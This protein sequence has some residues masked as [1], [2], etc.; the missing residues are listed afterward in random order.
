MRTIAALAMIVAALPAQQKKG[1]EAKKQAAQK[2]AVE[3]LPKLAGAI[4]GV[5]VSDPA[6]QSDWPAAAYARDGS[7]YVVYIEW[8]DKDADRVLARRR[9]AG[10]QWSAPIPIDDGAWDHYSPAVAGL[11]NGAL[12]IWSAQRDG[13]F[14][15]FAAEIAGVTPGRVERLTRAPHGDFN[16]R[17]VADAKGNV[18]LVWQSF[19]NGASDVYARRR[20]AGRWGPEVRV[21][22]SD[23]GDWEPSIALSAEGMAWISWDSYQHGNYDVFLR[24]FDG[25]RLGDIVTM[26]TEPAAQFHSSVAVDARG[27]VWVAWDQGGPHWGKDLSASSGMPGYSGLHSV[28][29]LRLR[30]WAN[31]R[32][33]DPPA[34]LN[35][36]LTAGMQQFAELPHLGFDDSGALWMVFRH[37]THRQPHEIYHF[38]ATRL[39][40]DRWTLP[41][42]LTASPGQNTQHASLTRA[43]HGGLSAVYS[44]DGRSPANLPKDQMHA[45]HY[46]VH[47]SELAKGAA[48]VKVAMKPAA[49]PP[50]GAPSPRR[51]RHTMRAGSR[52]YTLMMGDCHRHTDIRGHSGVDASVLDTY[53]Y[54]IDAGQ[55][56]FLGVTDHNEVLGGDW[57]DGLRDYHW[58]WTQKA[59]D[60]F[61]HAPAFVGV[62]SYEHSMARPGGH[63]NVLFLKRGA[64]LRP[65]D[66]RRQAPEP[67]NLPPAM[68]KFWE[69]RV[70]ADRG[71]MSVIVPHTFAA[72][73]LADWNWPNAR[74]DC[75]LEIYQGCRGSYEAWRMPDGEKRGGTQV[76]E[77]GHFAQDALAKG[78]VYG[79]VSFSDHGSTHNSWAAVWVEREDRRGILE[80]M[81]ARRTYAASDEI[82]LRATADGRMVGEEFAARADR[83]PR[84][85]AAVEAPDAILRIDIVKDGKYVYTTRPNSTRARISWRDTEARPGRS[86]YYLRV[87][88]RDP[89]APSGD[90]EI[91]WA[92]PFYVTYR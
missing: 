64:P 28:R 19:R 75:L 59:V 8:N 68:W 29:R 67:D 74:F 15:L 32:V 16:A 42:Q 35:E 13:N 26:T 38:Y 48:P 61:T 79:F 80:G 50:P 87:F 3:V 58:W 24:S 89:E 56:D 77:P 6:K 43:P 47:V 5:A 54:A 70:L 78:N 17:A 44:S 23:A 40:G 36:I 18:T 10:G 52:T 82:I 81:Y 76:D 2:A 45:L 22:P 72:G 88:Q 65:I 92:S 33:E 12:A 20:A 41:Y 60:L 14:E 21:S 27:R 53:R 63:R 66:R 86:Y 84:I 25:A 11:A 30:V 31:G 83:P 69:E 51:P 39:E 4:P 85:E 34:S 49:M 90:P 91:A 55:L 1:G 73:P 7:L 9:D 37:W 62:Y 46:V 71:Q 57:P